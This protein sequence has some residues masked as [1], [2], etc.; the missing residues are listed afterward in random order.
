LPG[1]RGGVRL[2]PIPIISDSDLLQIVCRNNLVRF[3]Y[4]FY[5]GGLDVNRSAY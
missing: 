3:N 1:R 5:I 4:I 2:L